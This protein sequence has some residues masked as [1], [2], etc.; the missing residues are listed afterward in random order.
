MGPQEPASAWIGDLDSGGDMV[1]GAGTS[2]TSA[3][4][5]WVLAGLIL[6]ALTAGG[7]GLRKAWQAQEAAHAAP[8]WP[9]A[10]LAAAGRRGPHGAG[11]VARQSRLIHL[12]G[13]SCLPCR[14]EAP[15]CW[16]WRH[17]AR[18]GPRRA[19]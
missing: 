6:A 14:E 7:Y 13:A 2:S 19:S 1:N 12:W 17:A 8:A 11:A 3:R 5:R 10:G 4:W 18:P 9:G 16:R 15:T